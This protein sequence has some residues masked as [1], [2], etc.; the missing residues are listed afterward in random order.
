[1]DRVD[2][3]FL[4]RRTGARGCRWAGWLVHVLAAID[5][6]SCPLEIASAFGQQ[7][8]HRGGNLIRLA[9][10]LSGMPADMEALRSSVSRPPMISVSTGPGAMTLTVI[11]Y[12]AKLAGTALTHPDHGR[13]GGGVHALGECA[14][15]VERGDRIR[16]GDGRLGHVDVGDAE[17]VDAG[18]VHRGVKNIDADFPAPITPPEWAQRLRCASSVASTGSRSFTTSS[19]GPDGLITGTGRQRSAVDCRSGGRP[20]SNGPFSAQPGWVSVARAVSNQ[21]R[22]RCN[23]CADRLQ[24]E[25]VSGEMSCAFRLRHA[26]H[27]HS[28]RTTLLSLATVEWRVQTRSGPLGRSRATCR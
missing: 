25:S 21:N 26:A 27:L 8:G 24:H 19:L 28:T 15:A 9:T 5:L 23:W 10:R 2:T 17:H 14:A 11:P 6:N 3:R 18:R 1:L 7:K 4:N 13:L 12:G 16:A 20:I 22:F